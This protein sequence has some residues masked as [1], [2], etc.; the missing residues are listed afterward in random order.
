M[1]F[2]VVAP[3][4]QLAESFED[5]ITLKAGASTV[6]EVPFV[7][8]PRPTIN[9]SWK[10]DSPLPS[11]FKPDTAVA[12]LTSLPLAKVKSEDAGDYTVKIKNELG[13]V[14]LTVHLVVLDKPTPP[15]NPQVTENTGDRVVVAWERPEFTGGDVEYILEVREASMRAGKQVLKTSELTAVVDKDLQLDKSY[16]FRVAAK[17]EVGQSDFVETKPISTSLGYGMSPSLVMKLIQ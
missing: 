14:T 9:W 10:D 4:L 1:L 8:S 13:S 16:V 5:T 17:N 11:R 3:T 6:I 2:F 15:R 12:G 7:A